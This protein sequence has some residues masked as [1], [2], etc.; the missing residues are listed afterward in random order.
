MYCESEQR[1][2]VFLKMFKMTATVTK[3]KWKYG[4]KYIGLNQFYANHVWFCLIYIGM[5]GFWPCPQGPWKAIVIN[6]AFNED[7]LFEYL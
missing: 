3:C 7:I 1:W 5:F 2:K 4:W 6:F